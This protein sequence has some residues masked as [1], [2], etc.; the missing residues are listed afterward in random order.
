MFGA[1]LAPTPQPPAAMCAAHSRALLTR[2]ECTASGG[3]ACEARK[4]L[5]P[6]TSAPSAPLGTTTATATGGGGGGAVWG[7]Y[8][9]G[10]RVGGVVG[11]TVVGAAVVVVGFGRVVVV[12]DRGTGRVIGA[13]SGSMA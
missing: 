7:G 1:P 13:G 4:L 9:A 3:R 12:V 11:G 2:F 5:M 8:V 10:G 6:P